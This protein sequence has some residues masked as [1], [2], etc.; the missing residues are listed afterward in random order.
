MSDDTNL[1]D[2]ARELIRLHMRCPELFEHVLPI[3]DDDLADAIELAEYEDW[4]MM[5][6]RP[7]PQNEVVNAAPRAARACT[8]NIQLR[9]DGAPCRLH[10]QISVCSASPPVNRQW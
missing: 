6:S 5:R 10:R 8:A 2:A 7:M 1:R 9:R 3:N 4:P